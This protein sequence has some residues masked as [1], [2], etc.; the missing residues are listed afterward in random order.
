[1]ANDAARAVSAGWRDRLNR[2]LETVEGVSFPIDM[3]FKTLIVVISTDFTGS[4]QRL[5]RQE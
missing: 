4:H 3:D 5:L 2:A 1:M